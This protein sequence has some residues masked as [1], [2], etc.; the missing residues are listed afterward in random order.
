MDVWV[1][2]AKYSLVL[3]KGR[4]IPVNFE[5]NPSGKKVKS[6][7]LTGQINDWNPAATP[8]SF[9]GSVFKATMMLNPGKY[10]YQVVVDGKWMLDPANPIKEDNN[11]GGFNSVLVVG[12]N[13][14]EKLPHLV[15]EST[16]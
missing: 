4:K 16:R 1:S 5:Y 10:H 6:V 12:N 11:M 9:D 3:R 2:G 13:Q 15:A 8:L 14:P 7:Q